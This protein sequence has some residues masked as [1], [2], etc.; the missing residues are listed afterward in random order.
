MESGAKIPGKEGREEAEMEV[1]P[2]LGLA[3]R[4]RQ[5]EEPITQKL[6]EPA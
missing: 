4:R 6:D 2:L 5:L 3:G 1:L